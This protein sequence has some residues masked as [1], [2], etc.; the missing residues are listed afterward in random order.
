MTVWYSSLLNRLSNTK[1]LWL[2]ASVLIKT[3]HLNYSWRCRWSLSKLII[4][5][6][7][8]KRIQQFCGISVMRILQSWSNYIQ[9]MSIDIQVELV[10]FRFVLQRC[11]C[12]WFAFAQCFIAIIVTPSMLPCYTCIWLPRQGIKLHLD[13]SH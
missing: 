6:L 5:E 3:H 12:E 9:N 2:K 7:M 13:Q 1:F 10:I 4:P 8:D 11:F